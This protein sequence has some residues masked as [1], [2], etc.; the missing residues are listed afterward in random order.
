MSASFRRLRL[1][2]LVLWLMGTSALTWLLLYF[3]NQKPHAP[4]RDVVLERDAGETLPALAK[5]LVEAQVI[6]QPNA[7]VWFMR[8][9]GAD[10]HLRQGAVV[11][12]RALSVRDLVP[13][14]SHG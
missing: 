13:R 5:R 2:L 12:N 6:Q 4:Y 9:L 7:F 8:L 11:V 3:P 14:L 1:A 10:A